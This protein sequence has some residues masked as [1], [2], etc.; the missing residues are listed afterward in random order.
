MRGKREVE[1][2]LAL[3]EAH[4]V[5]LLEQLVIARD[6][7]SELTSQVSKLQDALISVRAPAAYLDQQEERYEAKQPK[8]S[9]E[10]L[11]KN[12]ITKK[13][14]EE[15]LNGMEGAML[16]TPEDLDDL[17]VSGLLSDVEPSTSL[18][19]NDES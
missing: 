10:T 11:E 4:I 16:R 18:H 5:S 2:E 1:R 13:V 15:Y 12:R 9:P 19:G 8:P 3:A 6:E 14:T 17:L 7:K